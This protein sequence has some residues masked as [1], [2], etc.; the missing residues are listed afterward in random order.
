MS[1]GAVA[2]HQSMGQRFSNPHT[3]QLVLLLYVLGGWLILLEHS[4]VFGPLFI[5][6]FFSPKFTFRSNSVEV[7]SYRYGNV[8]S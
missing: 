4:H 2:I 5:R 7:V 8:I 6:F 3:Y 1:N